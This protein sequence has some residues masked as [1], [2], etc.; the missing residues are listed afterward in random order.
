[1]EQVNQKDLLK[2]VKRDSRRYCKTKIVVAVI[3]S[4]LF[5]LSVASC[6]NKN[7]RIFVEIETA[8][9][10]TLKVGQ[11]Y[12]VSLELTFQDALIEFKV[13]QSPVDSKLVEIDDRFYLKWK[14][15]TSFKDSFTSVGFTV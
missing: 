11:L 4:I 13:K 7:D 15:K 1:M 8:H 5:C 6:E 2:K 9:D 12:Y 3:V 14:P 10:A